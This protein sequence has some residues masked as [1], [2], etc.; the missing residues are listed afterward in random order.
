MAYQLAATISAGSNPQPILYSNSSIW[1]A[2]VGSSQVRRI[3]PISNTVTATISD[4]SVLQ[5]GRSLAEDN[6]GNVWVAC[7][8]FTNGSVSRINPA[9]N[10]ITAS[11]L[12]TNGDQPFGLGM[13]AGD[14]WAS[15]AFVGGTFIR[16]NTTTLS[17]T[18]SSPNNLGYAYNFVDDGTNVW[19]DT[20]TICYKVAPATNA[21][22]A[23]TAGIV[24]HNSNGF[25]H[26]AF[27]Y[28][29]RVTNTGI[30]RVNS[31]TNALT[32][33]T[34]SANPC[35]GIS[36]DGTDLIVTDRGGKLYIVNPT[37]FAVKQTISA[38]GALWGVTFD[39]SS[40]WA[41]DYSNNNCLRYSKLGV[42]WV[43]GHAWG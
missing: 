38:P 20:G 24:A 11:T 3:D 23:I 41:N 25:V 27:G 14:L 28:I 36:N 34:L 31:T 43:R 6:L 5:S 26:Y 8:N 18:Y 22:T 29:W 21:R 12:T 17:F 4:T 2:T 10:T 15:A 16:I 13:G 1:T 7:S 9:T 35:D 40:I 32:T 33:I 30:Q 19:F 37:S 39:G 42:G